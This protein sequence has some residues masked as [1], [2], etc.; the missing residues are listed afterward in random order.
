L[1]NGVVDGRH[2]LAETERF[3]YSLRLLRHTNA[4]A[5]ECYPKV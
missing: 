1:C 5:H 4:G 2:A 3:E